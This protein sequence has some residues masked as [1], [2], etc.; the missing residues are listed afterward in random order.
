M[1]LGKPRIKLSNYKIRTLSV[2]VINNQGEKLLIRQ[3]SLQTNILKKNLIV[4]K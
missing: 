1:L 4:M 3:D 2:F